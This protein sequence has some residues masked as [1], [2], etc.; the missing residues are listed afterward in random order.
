MYGNGNIDNVFIPGPQCD[1]PGNTHD[2]GKTESMNADKKMTLT[3]GDK[4]EFTCPTGFTA[5]LSETDTTPITTATCTVGSDGAKWKF[6]NDPNTVYVTPT[7][8]G[9]YPAYGTPWFVLVSTLE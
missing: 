7:C 9:K 5:R 1:D 8:Y 4:I 2:G 3:D 6:D